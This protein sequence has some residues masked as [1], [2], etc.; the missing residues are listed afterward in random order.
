MVKSSEELTPNEKEVLHLL[1]IEFF[2]I[3]QVSLRRHTSDKAVYQIV[4]RLVKKGYLDKQN[5]EALKKVPPYHLEL[6]KSKVKMEQWR[7]HNLH[8]VVMPY[9]FFPRYHKVRLEKGGYGINHRE[10]VIKLHEETVEIQLQQFQDFVDDDKYL[11]TRK[12][13]ESFNR[14]LREVSAKFGFCVFKEGKANIKLVQEHLAKNP[15][16]VAD[17]S[18]LDFL[19]IRDIYDGKIWFT[20]DKSK[21]HEHEYTKTNRVLSDAEKVEPYF[22]DFKDKQPLTNSELEG[23]FMQLLNVVEKI[24]QQN[25]ETAIGLKM[26]AKLLESQIPKETITKEE[27][28][29][30]P[31]YIN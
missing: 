31:D 16:S 28:Y 2:T 25:N 13:E 5:F 15:S 24:T 29:K 12:A 14:T 30:R 23:R 20:I 18:K 4:D 1:T 9:S 8:F 3:K 6:E 11:A 21:G 27:V 17:G 19:N 7:Y 26:I 22:N 10:W